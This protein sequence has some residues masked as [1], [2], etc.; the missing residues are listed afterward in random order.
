MS[1]CEQIALSN[2][3][4]IYSQITEALENHREPGEGINTLP[5]K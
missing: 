3:G 4:Q 2:L 5:L 1:P